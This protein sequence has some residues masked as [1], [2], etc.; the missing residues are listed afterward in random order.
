[1]VR[2]KV[3]VR[4]GR[5]EAPIGHGAYLRRDRSELARPL[6]RFVTDFEPAP[7]LVE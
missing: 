3:V 6:G 5:L 2:G 4:D 7:R 1:M